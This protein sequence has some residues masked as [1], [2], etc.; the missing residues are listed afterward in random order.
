MPASAGEDSIPFGGT[1]GNADVATIVLA[2]QGGNRAAYGTLYT[3]YVSYVHAVLLAHVPPDE[4]PDLVQDVFLH[5]L[6]KLGTLREPAAFGSW[7]AQIARNMARMSRRSHLELVE[8]DEQL[9]APEQSIAGSALDGDAV[10]AAIRGLPEAYSEPLLMRLIGGM[11]GE[12]I[13]ARTG[14][15]H[16]SVRVN[17]HR[18]MAF[19]RQKLG[20]P[21]S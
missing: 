1:P 4:A 21:R 11:S 18:G 14:L 2:A 7:I 6:R 9:A 12:E 3:R 5:A 20:G 17:L 10:L 8:L 19:L 15:T 13:A 16:A